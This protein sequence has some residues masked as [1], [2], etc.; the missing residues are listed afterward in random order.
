MRVVRPM[1]LEARCLERS[2]ESMT[3]VRRVS[4]TFID[5]SSDNCLLGREYGGVS[6]S[7]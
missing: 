2:I 5:S 4:E 7:I 6:Q 3:R 1:V